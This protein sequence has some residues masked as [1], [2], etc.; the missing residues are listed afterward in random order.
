M[1]FLEEAKARGFIHQCT[2][3]EA[4]ESAMEK[5]IKAYIGFDCTADSLHVGSLMQLMILRLLQKYKHKPTVLF[6]GATTRIGDP[7]GKDAS[8]KMLSDDEIRKNTSGIEECV[9]TFL[10]HFVH[11]NNN[12]WL[13]NISYMDILREIGTHFTINRMLAMDSVKLRLE[14]E[15]PMTFLEFNY[16][17]FQSYDF[18]ELFRT[19]DVILQIGGSDQWGNITSGVDLIRRMASV[20]SAYILA[21]QAFGLTTPLILTAA[22]NKMGKSV[23][24][25]IWLSKD[26]T[27]VYDYWQFWRN[28]DDKDVERFLKLFTDFP[29]DYI[30]VLMTYD[31]NDTKGFLANAATVICHGSDYAE[32]I[33]EQCFSIDKTILEEG[34]VAFRLFFM[35]GLATSNGDARR[36]INGDGAKINDISINENRNVT[37]ADI[38]NGSI[39][40]SA[41]KKRHKFVVV[42]GVK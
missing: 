9:K 32:K 31:I 27:S 37:M 4:L 25:A 28:T 22:G 38:V 42:K 15:N 5:P 10:P 39:K 20:P 30:D 33:N 24:G 23:N 29:L 2:D 35:A 34:I 19:R 8:R 41:G 36:L 7:S 3:I 1:T 40:L 11:I 13:D 14:K 21:G 12:E 16:I 17:I 6:G 26:K 18:L